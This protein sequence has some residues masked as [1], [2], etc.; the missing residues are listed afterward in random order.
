MTPIEIAREI[1]ADCIR[2]ARKWEGKPITGHNLAMMYGETLAMVNVVARL[3][4]GI[5]EGG[6]D[7][8]N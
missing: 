5:L 3:I 6:S 4:E 2:D 7:G 1:Q 8:G